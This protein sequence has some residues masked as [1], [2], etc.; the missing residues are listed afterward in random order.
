MVYSCQTITLYAKT[1]A[2]FEVIQHLLLITNMTA[3]TTAD[4]NNFSDRGGKQNF[5]AL[6]SKPISLSGMSSAYDDNGC[7]AM[8]LHLGGV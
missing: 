6:A 4:E 8:V 5:L 2:E 1:R 7:P 3:I